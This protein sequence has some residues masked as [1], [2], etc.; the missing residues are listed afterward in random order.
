MNPGRFRLRLIVVTSPRVLLPTFKS[1]NTVERTGKGKMR[2]LED[3][4]SRGIIVSWLVF[5]FLLVTEAGMV[6][7]HPDSEYLVFRWQVWLLLGILLFAVRDLVSDLRCR[8]CGSHDDLS[9]LGLLRS[10]EVLCL[11]CMSWD[12]GIIERESQKESSRFDGEYA[13]LVKALR[14]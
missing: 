1:S 10:R 7:F 3:F 6:A 9:F 11:R 5:A 2:S 13:E 4:L 12:P 14:D 8:C